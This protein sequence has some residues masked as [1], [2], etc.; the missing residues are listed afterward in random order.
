MEE[1]N[2]RNHERYKYVKD[3]CR[4]DVC[5]AGWKEF[6]RKRNIQ[7]RLKRERERESKLDAAPLIAL[8]YEQVDTHSS[9]GRKLRYWRRYGV[10]VYTADKFCCEMGY[11]PV[12][13]FGDAWWKGAFDEQQG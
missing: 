3:K 4:C 7:R 12:E 9:L 6:D 13:V 8:L 11:H 1:V 5:V 2:K 10:D